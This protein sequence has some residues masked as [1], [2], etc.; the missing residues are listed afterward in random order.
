ML[1]DFFGTFSKEAREQ[2]DVPQELLEII[3][4]ELPRNFEYRRDDNGEYRIVPTE[5]ANFVRMNAE[6]DIDK[7]EDSDLQEKIQKVPHDKQIAYLARLLERIPVKNTVVGDKD[8]KIP[9]EQTMDD[10]INGSNVIISNQWIYL[11]QISD[12]VFEFET[13]EGAIVRVP[14]RQQVYDS[15]TE[16]KYVNTDFPSLDIE[17][18][19]YAPLI[20][21][22][23]EGAITSK[24]N[25]VSVRY[26]VTPTKADS[27]KD[28]LNALYVFKGFYEGTIK[29]NGHIPERIQVDRQIDFEQIDEKID[30]WK[31]A[32]Q[33]ENI[34]KRKINS[35]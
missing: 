2:R 24:E 21:Q 28:A 27:V 1:G 17:I 15:L 34:L 4:K 33:L 22:I 3:N 9:I 6:L 29:V 13:F 35:F 32:L 31:K 23:E 20:E 12:R 8:K 16:M 14:F 11:R 5:D 18:Y 10:P 30:F 26:K 25:P 7:L 19:V